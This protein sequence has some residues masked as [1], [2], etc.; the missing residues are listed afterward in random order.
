MY[1]CRATRSS[2]AR[3]GLAGG[4][5]RPFSCA[6]HDDLGDPDATLSGS[7]QVV[8]LM[9]QETAAGQRVIDNAV[10]RDRLMRLQG[11]VLAMHYDHL[12]LLS[13][14]LNGKD[15]S[16]AAMIVKLQGT[17]LRHE[18]EGL[19]VDALGEF[20]ILFEEGRHLHETAVRGRRCTC[21]IWA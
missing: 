3:P 14:K 17:E 15:A 5:H 7:T 16:L 18:L 13:A 1:A 9:K 6:E 21:S 8:E 20:G 2:V 10:Y 12:R 19:A 11:R 4:E